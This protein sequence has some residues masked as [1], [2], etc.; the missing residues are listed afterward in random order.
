MVHGALRGTSL[1]RSVPWRRRKYI[2][3]VV[4]DMLTQQSWR[5]WQWRVHAWHRG[6]VRHTTR[7]A[8]V[9]PHHTTPHH[10]IASHTILS[11]RAASSTPRFCAPPSL[12]PSTLRPCTVSATE[13]TA[14]QPALPVRV[15]GKHTVALGSDPQ[16]LEVCYNPCKPRLST[17][18]A[19]II[20]IQMSDRKYPAASTRA[21]AHTHINCCRCHGT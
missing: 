9:C 18:F 5:L 8:A 21:R 3:P 16:E 20:V 1:R 12:K 14:A 2:C 19:G 15:Q 7:P 4:E 13:T 6:N 10:A 17:G 11:Q